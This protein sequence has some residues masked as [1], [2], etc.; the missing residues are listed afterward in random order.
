VAILASLVVVRQVLVNQLEQRITTEMQQELTEFRLLTDGINPATGLHFGMDLAASADT[1]LLRHQPLDDESLMVFVNGDY[2]RGSHNAPHDLTDDPALVNGWTSLT[3]ERWGEVDTP[4]G[5]ARWVAAPVT[6]G[7]EVRGHFVVAQFPD[8]RHARLDRAVRMMAAG[9]LSVVAVLGVGAYLAMGRAL[10]PL[11]T[12]TDT[13]RAIEETDLSRRIP[14]RGSDEVADLGRTFNAMVERLERAFAAQ[15]VLL[16]DIGHELR[17]P[18]TIV[19][20][21]LEVM[22][23]DPAE[24]RETLDLVTDEL[25]RMNRMV[26]DLL[27]L[28][29][30]ERPDFLR[31][32]RVDVAC[33]MADTYRKATALGDREWVLGEVEPV[34]LVADP[35][36]LTQALMQ[37][38]QNAV[39]F[40]GPGDRI[41]LSANVSNS[42][43]LLAVSDA[44]PGIEPAAQDRIFE[45]FA[46]AAAGQPRAEGAGLGLAIVAAIAAAHRGKVTVASAPGAGAT[47]TLFIPMDTAEGRSTP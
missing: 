16:S 47:F 11:R 14:V 32:A 15:Q 42:R 35:Q 4:A 26:D 13:A 30:A 27:V 21:H 39:Q 2:Y 46:R 28:A 17:T 23:H 1:Y 37:L 33:M 44:G 12:A 18:I 45:R 7:G 22:G 9:G 31:L 8:E 38:A 36:R 20:G 29:R 5:R 3:E 43:L 24:Q 6:I 40:T 41:E 25:D 34:T 10:R 19:R